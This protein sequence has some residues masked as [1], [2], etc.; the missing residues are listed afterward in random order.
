MKVR[1]VEEFH[2]GGGSPITDPSKIDVHMMG[3]GFGRDTSS[4]QTDPGGYPIPTDINPFL[5]LKE[6]VSG[7]MTPG[8]ILTAQSIT[9]GITAANSAGFDFVELQSSGTEWAAPYVSVAVPSA[10]ITIPQTELLI[11]TGLDYS[12]V[13]APQNVQPPCA[14]NSNGGCR[15]ANSQEVV[16][17]MSGLQKPLYTFTTG[18]QNAPQS[19]LWR[20]HLHNGKPFI[21]TGTYAL[22]E[23]DYLYDAKAGRLGFHFH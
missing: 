6:M 5:R 8:F 21:N 9:L 2:P 20:H 7:A 17:T 18:G 15:V 10:K 13:Q 14:N 23:F 4:G 3:V 22:R 12:I 1:M 16:L 11:D 19:V